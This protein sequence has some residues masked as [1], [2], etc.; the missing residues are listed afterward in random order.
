MF[1]NIYPLPLGADCEPRLEHFCK[2]PEALRQNAELPF[3]ASNQAE[4]RILNELASCKN[5]G[6]GVIGEVY[7][8]LEK[9]KRGVVQGLAVFRH[10]ELVSAFQF[11]ILR[12][13]RHS[14]I[15]C[16]YNFKA[17]LR[18]VKNLKNNKVQLIAPYKTYPLPLREG[19]KGRGP[20]GVVSA[21][22]LTS[23]RRGFCKILNL[24]SILRNLNITLSLT[25]SLGEGIKSYPLYLWEREEFQCEFYEH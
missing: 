9:V 19:I 25:L 16:W 24:P 7:N 1:G 3:H 4:G 6:E 11:V 20:L 23:L 2:E 21:S 13:Q 12:C 18:V 5:S 15:R 14:P 8:V 17:S 22:Q 10:A